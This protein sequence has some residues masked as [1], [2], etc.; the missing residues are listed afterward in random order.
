MAS[1]KIKFRPSA[2]PDNEGTIYIQ[3]IHNRKVRLLGTDYHVYPSE[4]DD[5]RSNV[6]TKEGGE[7]L[8]FIMSLR[9]R[10]RWDVERLVKIEKRIDAKELEYTVDDIVDEF[11]RYASEYSLFNYMKN[12]IARLSQNGHYGTSRAYKSTLASF[13]KFRKDEDIM[14]DCIT[15]DLMEDYAAW[16]KSNGNIPNT[17]SFYNRILKATYLRAVEAD[18]IE[19]RHPFRKVYT[20]IDKT[21]KRALAIPL[22]RKIK[23]LDL[24]LKPTLAFTRDMFILS[25][26]LR[27][28]SFIDMAF[29]KKTDLNEKVL[30]Y[31]RHKTGQLLTIEWTKEMQQIVNRYPENPRQY[32]LPI[33]TKETPDDLIYYY[34]VLSR[35]NRNLKKVGKLAGIK[36]SIS[37]YNARHSWA[38]AA[39]VK[40]IPISVISEGMGHDSEATTHIYLS[41][42][43]TEIVDR[44]NRKLISSLN[45]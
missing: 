11:K 44:A 1:I 27:G 16:L 21:V 26:Y 23:E 43:D 6:T 45:D 20:G 4:W 35:F 13:K 30:T 12:L 41:S 39:K 10:I 22:V 25:F 36:V 37:S 3:L 32:F 42:L 17:I 38:N 8:A 28:M 33:L 2:V 15:P 9:D 18:I 19:D 29:L 14:L 34:G 7:R 24:S 40:R 5:S 31:R